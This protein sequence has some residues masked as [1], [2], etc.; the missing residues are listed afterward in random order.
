MRRKTF[1][2]L[3]VIVLLGVGEVLAPSSEPVRFA[4]WDLIAAL[5]Q[6]G[7]FT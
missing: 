7:G 3:I 2:A 1:V 5:T 4:D 6:G